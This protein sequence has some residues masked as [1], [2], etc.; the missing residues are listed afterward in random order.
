[1]KAVAGELA[2]RGILKANIGKIL[3]VIADQCEDTQEY[4]DSSAIQSILNGLRVGN[5]WISRKQWQESE[6]SHD[7]SHDTPNLRAVLRQAAKDL[8]WHQGDLSSEFVRTKLEAAA[9]KQGCIIGTP[10][11]FRQTLSR[12]MRGI[13]KATTM[14]KGRGKLTTIWRKSGTTARGTV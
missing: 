1:M 4:K 3:M 9:R 10:E 6:V 8:P 11:R 13:A 14:T 7:M 12:A 5:V 2:T